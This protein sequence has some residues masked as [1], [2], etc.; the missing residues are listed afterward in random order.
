M[1]RFIFAL[2]EFWRP[3]NK[4]GGVVWTALAI[5]V[6]VGIW[7]GLIVVVL[8][9]HP[10]RGPTVVSQP[11]ISPQPAWEL[12]TLL[13]E[14][15]EKTADSGEEYQILVIRGDIF[16]YHA[17]KKLWWLLSEPANVTVK[18]ALRHRVE[19]RALTILDEDGKEHRMEIVKKAQN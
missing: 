8:V 16:T 10:Y 19:G 3:I 17:R 18:A 15:R 11:V 7:I 14:R 2:K 5:L 6:A 12:G 1:K 9:S 13:D 4:L